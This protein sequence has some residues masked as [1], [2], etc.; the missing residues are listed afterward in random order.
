MERKARRADDRPPQQGAAPAQ[1]RRTFLA[2]SCWRSCWRRAWRSGLWLTLWYLRAHLTNQVDFADTMFIYLL[3]LTMWLVAGYLSVVRFLSYLDLRIRHEGWEVELRMRAEG[4]QLARQMGSLVTMRDRHY[5][6]ALAALMMLTTAG[7][8]R[9]IDDPVGT[10]RDAL[11]RWWE[12]PWYDGAKDD[13]RT[14][15]VQ[16][17]TPTNFG[18]FGSGEDLNIFVWLGIGLLLLLLIALFFRAYLRED[19]APAT[20]G[21]RRQADPRSLIERAEALPIAV[22]LSKVDLLAEANRLSQQGDYSRAIVFFYSHFFVRLDQGHKIRLAAGKT[23]RQYLRELSSATM[24]KMLQTVMLA[25]ED[26][27]FGKHRIGREKVRSLLGAARTLDTP[28]WR[29]WPHDDDH[30]WHASE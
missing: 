28:R 13:V 6:I 7:A 19:V 25:F 5:R 10:G 16:P 24:R 14:L 11:R 8:A 23:N 15:D 1:Q 29:R 30:G 2:F 17:P 9:A 12:Y 18:G 3:P 21:G 27:F 26:A 20:A 4:A 22:D